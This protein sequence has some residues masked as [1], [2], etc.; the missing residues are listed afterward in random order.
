[1][2]K[3]CNKLF[4][5]CFISTVSF[6]CKAEIDQEV[7]KSLHEKFST[8]EPTQWGECV[9]GIKTKL[10]TNDK[11]IAITLDLCGSLSDGCDY[12]YLEFFEREQIP[13]TI[14]VTTKW[15]NNHPKD[16]NVLIQNSLFEIENHGLNH[17]PASINGASIYGIAGTNNIEELVEEVEESALFI[18]K[19]TKHKPRLYRS[20]TAYYDEIAVQIINALG[21][22]VMGFSILGD[23]GTTYSK[24]QTYNAVSQ[25]REGDI[26]ILH[27]NHPAKD[28]AL[29]AIK[30]IKELK[31]QGFKFVKLSDYKLK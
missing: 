31:D 2:I 17:K 5:I 6:S 22:K 24:D 25:S 1:M 3:I 16:F 30:A 19:L 28:C 4:F 15:I 14:F 20:G 21:Y 26:I 13:A 9:S 23:A 11:V 18:E 8:L 29:G 12:R 27:M 10:E 7:I